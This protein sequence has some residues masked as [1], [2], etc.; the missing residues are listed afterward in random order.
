MGE[1]S[2]E[3]EALVAKSAALIVG[4]LDDKRTEITRALQ[5][6]LVSELAEIGGDGEL[7]ALVYDSV[8]GNLDTFIPAVRHGIPIDH[9]EPPTVRTVVSCIGG[10]GAGAFSATSRIARS[11]CSSERPCRLA[12][13]RKIR[14]SPS[15]SSMTASVPSW[16]PMM[17]GRTTTAT[18]LP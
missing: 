14:T 3:D 16:L 15:V 9:V 7:L 17:S 12:R 4:Q 13:S 1:E 11:S 8:Q 10:S 2:R 6:L 18:G 5:E